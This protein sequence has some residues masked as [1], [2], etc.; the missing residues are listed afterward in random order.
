MKLRKYIFKLD[1]WVQILIM[2]SV[3]LILVFITVFMLRII[4]RHGEK[5]KVPDMKGYYVEDVARKTGKFNFQYII[6]DS[7]YDKK[8]VPGTIVAHSPEAGSY[9][10]NGRKFYITLAARTPPFVKMPNLHDLSLRQAA[11]L[12]ETY[13]IKIGN[14]TTVPSIGKAVVEQY[15]KGRRIAP[16]EKIPQD[17]VITLEVGSGGNSDNDNNI[18]NN[19]GGN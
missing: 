1:F 6:R 10:K 19:D 3:T 11:S 18:I 8:S 4:T 2:A 7:V 13:G 17:A 5:I 12:L 9:V 16:G 15:Y 14:V